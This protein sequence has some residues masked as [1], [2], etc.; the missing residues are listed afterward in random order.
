MAGV[1]KII[2]T[3]GVKS[4]SAPTGPAAATRKRKPLNVERLVKQY[5]A[6]RGIRE[7]AITT[8]WSYGTIQRRLAEANVL[9]PRGR[10]LKSQRINGKIKN[11]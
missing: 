3:P 8:G 9:R 11:R 5:V 4:A 1:K 2:P 6:G 10:T 7:L